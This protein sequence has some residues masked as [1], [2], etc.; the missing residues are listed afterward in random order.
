[1]ELVEKQMS[2]AAQSWSNRVDRRQPT[3]TDYSYELRSWVQRAI[4][5]AEEMKDFSKKG[6]L[7]SLLKD[8]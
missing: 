1:M 4:L 2:T 6:K 5:E 3:K 8:L 7:L